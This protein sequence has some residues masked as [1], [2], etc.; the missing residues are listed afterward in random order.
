MKY[1]VLERNGKTVITNGR[2][3]YT[4]AVDDDPV[5]FAEKVRQDI[6]KETGN[7]PKFDLG[8]TEVERM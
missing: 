7:E 5:E 3:T 8:K 4:S 6:I 2:S 1:R